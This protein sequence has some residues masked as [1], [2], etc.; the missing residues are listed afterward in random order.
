MKKKTLTF[1][2]IAISMMSGCASTTETSE[3]IAAENADAAKNAEVMQEASAA[4]T[5][6]IDLDE[7]TCRRIS[8]VGTRVKTKV[9]ATNREWQA[10]EERAQKTTEKMQREAAATHRPDG[11]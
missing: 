1:S 8:K 9:C 2:F 10:V 6:E 4:Q 5:A 11:G 7:V 3:Q